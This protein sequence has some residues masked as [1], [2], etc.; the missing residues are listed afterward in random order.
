MEA[1]MRSSGR[2]DLRAILA[3]ALMGLF[4]PQEVDAQTSK[5][6]RVGLCHVGLDHDPPSLHSLKE[7]LARLGY[8]DGKN[9]VFDWRNQASAETAD[10]QIR[11]WTAKNYDL[12]VAFEDQCVRAA[13]TATS[14]IPIVFAHTSDPVDAG[15]IQSLSRPGGNVT[16]PVT[17]ITLTG[18][19]LELLKRIDPHLRRVLVLADHHDAASPAWI[20]AARKTAAGLGVD[21][22]ERD[23]PTAV[24]L[25]RAFAELK[26]GEVGGVIAG[27]MYVVT[28]L[29]TPILT[30]AEHARVPVAA[31]NPNWVKSGALLSYGHD[32]AAAGPMAAHYIDKI[33]KGAKPSDLPAQEV[34]KFIL[35][36][37]LR[38]AQRLGLSIPPDVL[39]QADE[40]IE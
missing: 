17:N 38:T 34:S 24:E 21:I 9:L 14:T 12:I 29:T 8:V 37:N 19:R 13:K 30:M 20:E 3:V 26:P 31:H 15:F 28:N 16:G 2:C 25:E 5:V 39:V 27:S 1:G 10:V 7:E 18:K 35:V 33:F 4:P 40:V 32:V 6:W 36:I 23:T 11:D 22:V